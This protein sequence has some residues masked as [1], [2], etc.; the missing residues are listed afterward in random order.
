MTVLML[1]RTI[2][3]LLFALVL[4]SASVARAD[5]DWQR[6]TVKDGVTVDRRTVN[7][8]KLYETRAMSWAPLSPKQIFDVLCDRQRYPEFLS[9]L[10]KQEVISEVGDD[11]I[12]YDQ[13][14]VPLVSDRDYVIR[15]HKSVDEA[16][17]LY[18]LVFESA[19]ALGPPEAKGHVRARNI[20]GGW[21]LKPGARG[22][23]D[24]TY[25]LYSDPG[26]SI[27]NWIVNLVQKKEVPKYVR[28]IVQRATEIQARAK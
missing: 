20:R 24:I 15:V 7:G 8:S 25:S 23:V 14:R 9:Y 17:Q 19:D 26:G 22:G 12:V 16:T 3:A 28:L 2:S 21:W 5:G 10:K 1:S 4:A 27:P 11:A 6:V 18:S 13:I